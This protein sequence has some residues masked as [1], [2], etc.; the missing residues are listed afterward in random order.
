MSARINSAGK[1]Y[2]LDRPAEPDE[3]VTEEDLRDAPK[4]A[5]LLTRLLK[6]VAVM[7]RRFQPE[8]LDFEDRAV[9]SGDALRLTHGLNA[10]VRWSIVDWTPTTPGDAALFEKDASTD[11][12]T[13]VLLVGN[14]GTVSIRVE[15]AG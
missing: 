4:L 9:I 14:S 6:D 12:K 11:L 10:R 8:T 15:L 1:V 5:R 13:L 7:R 2:Q 3:R